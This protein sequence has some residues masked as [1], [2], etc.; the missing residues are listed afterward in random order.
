MAKHLLVHL[1]ASSS[2]MHSKT[3]A[4]PNIETS[5]PTDR[6]RRLSRLLSGSARGELGK[7]DGFDPGSSPSPPASDTAEARAAGERERAA[8]GRSFQPGSSIPPQP[9]LDRSLGNELWR[10]TAVTLRPMT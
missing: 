6:Q 7:A 1:L 3:W 2:N 9:V 10:G 8:C 4:K 5:D